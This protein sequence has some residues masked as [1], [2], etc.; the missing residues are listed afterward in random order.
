[1]L[2]LTNLGRCLHQSLG[3]GPLPPLI[4]LFHLRLLL[5]V[6]IGSPGV[7]NGPIQELAQVLDL[8]GAE[9]S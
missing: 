9:K 3:V 8:G 2:N 6:L 4:E 1:M 7:S 5:I